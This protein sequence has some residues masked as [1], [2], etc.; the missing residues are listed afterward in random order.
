MKLNSFDRAILQP[1][2]RYQL[3][4]HGIAGAIYGALKQGVIENGAV[5]SLNANSQTA[6]TI[7]E[8]TK[9]ATEQATL[10]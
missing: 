8:V 6:G 1:S 3:N 2:A 10:K 7:R 4:R 9:P 5:I